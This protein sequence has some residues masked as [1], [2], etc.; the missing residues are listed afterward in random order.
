LPI[1]LGPS[2]NEAIAFSSRGLDGAT[3]N[4]L[5]SPPSPVGLPVLQTWD[6]PQL[7]MLFNFCCFFLSLILLY[8]TISFTIIIKNH[9]HS[10]SKAVTYL[11]P[12]RCEL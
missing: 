11:Y 12:V 9:M 2:V 10:V 1:K 6:L 7:G 5:R 8:L 3:A 4:E